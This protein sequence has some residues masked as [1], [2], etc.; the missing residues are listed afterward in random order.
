MVKKAF[1]RFYNEG[2]FSDIARDVIRPSDEE[3]TRNGRARS[4]KLRIAVK[5]DA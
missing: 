4:A 2:I 1:K 3:C 5:E